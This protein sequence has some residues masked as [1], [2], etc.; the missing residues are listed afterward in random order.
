MFLSSGYPLVLLEKCSNGREVDRIRML[1]QGGLL[2]RSMNS[3]K[4]MGSES[5]VAMAIYFA[6]NALTKRYLL[7]QPNRREP[8]VRMTTSSM[9]DHCSSF[10]L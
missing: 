3:M 2:V 1:L 7:Y 4:N 5:F 10:I 9:L 8:D 6:N